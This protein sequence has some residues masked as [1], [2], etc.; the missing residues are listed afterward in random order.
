MPAEPT[1][2]DIK[3]SY[4]NFILDTFQHPIP[5]TAG[6][7]I[8]EVYQRQK[9]HATKTYQD[10][11]KG[12][13]RNWRV[14]DFLIFNNHVPIKNSQKHNRML[15][16]V[17]GYLQPITSYLYKHP[18]QYGYQKKACYLLLTDKI[19]A[20]GINNRNLAELAE[21]CVNIEFSRPE[22]KDSF[23][24]PSMGKALVARAFDTF[25]GKELK[26]FKDKCFYK[27]KS[28]PPYYTKNSNNM[29]QL[30]THMLQNW[31]TG[32]KPLDE[33][34]SQDKG[35]IV[36]ADSF[37][38]ELKDEIMALGG[39]ICAYATS[40]SHHSPPPAPSLSGASAAS[41][42]ICPPYY[43]YAEAS[44]DNKKNI[45][46]GINQLVKQ[47]QASNNKATVKFLKYADTL[48]YL[49][50][51]KK[52]FYKDHTAVFQK[53]Q[54]MVNVVSTNE[55]NLNDNHIIFQQNGRIANCFGTTSGK[56]FQKM[57]SRAGVLWVKR[58]CANEHE[59]LACARMTV[60][61]CLLA[62]F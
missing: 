28:C 57:R 56:L 19:M 1:E 5:D 24:N 61:C 62:R 53:A 42:P 34:R 40:H 16:C 22:V 13:K 46:H 48:L 49:S 45:S 12:L 51:W 6:W 20:L 8:F 44:E 55:K 2:N 37:L 31:Q 27:N 30:M 9:K 52:F 21:K 54:A 60:S 35:P 32:K 41:A 29:E 50:G 11:N 59:I 33:K 58:V 36:S 3:I 47:H 39:S 15:A 7:G 43:Q 38:Q 4:L 18:S 26:A 10:I 25:L 17:T 23:R 14:I